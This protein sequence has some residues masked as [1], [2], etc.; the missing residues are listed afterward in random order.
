MA[1]FRLEDNFH[2]HPK[3][4]AA[5]N[6]ATGLWVR[7]GTWSSSY[8]TDGFIP[9]NI[10]RT[11]GRR[12]E[13]ERALDARLWVPTDEGV[14]MPDYLDYNPSRGDVERRRKQDAERKRAERSKGFANVDRAGDGRFTPRHNTDRFD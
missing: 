3:V 9:L 2:Q 8:S 7:C 14:L 11:M 5:G 10:V 12:S 13:I 6:A 1:W 4:L